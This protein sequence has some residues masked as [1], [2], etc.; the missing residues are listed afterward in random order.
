MILLKKHLII[1][2]RVLIRCREACLALSNEKCRMLSKE[3]IVLGHHISSAG[4]K[5]DPTKIKVIMDLPAPRSQKEVRIFLGHVG[6]YR[7]FI[8][9]FTKIATPMF[10]FLVKDIDFVWDSQCQNAFEDLKEKLSTTP[11]LRGPNWSLP[12]HISTDASDTTLRV[13][14][15]KK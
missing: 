9:N 7:R 5:V 13:V 4:I 14:L 12:F 2:E 15:G 6:Y 11:V 3:G 1:L 10:K 8:E